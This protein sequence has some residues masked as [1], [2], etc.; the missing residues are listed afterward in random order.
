MNY[1][2]HPF[3]TQTLIQFNEEESKHMAV[4]RV[5]VGDEV[6]VMNGMGEEAIASI[7]EAGKR[8][9]I[10]EITDRKRH[11]PRACKFHIAV[12]PVKNT[13]RLEWMVEKLCEIG[14]EQILFI[15][16]DK[17]ERTRLNQERLNKI[18][19]SACKQSKNFYFPTIGENVTNF[20]AFFTNTVAEQKFIAYCGSENQN[21]IDVMLPKKDTVIVIG[22]EGDFTPEEFAYAST[23]GFKGI[24]LGHTRL[25]TETAA[26]FSGA[27]FK[28]VNGY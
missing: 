11:I 5:R 25:R 14:V 20:Q 13:D 19:V 3:S 27:T 15:D 28:I 7:T 24:S 22:P 8:Y 2:Y 9:F 18:M 4:L 16:T 17:T 10:A 23:N 21:L 1:F 26:I 6:H 12:A